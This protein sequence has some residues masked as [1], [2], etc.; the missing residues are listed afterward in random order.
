MKGLGPLLEG[1]PIEVEIDDS[2]P[3]AVFDAEVIEKVIRQL[4]D[5][6]IKYSPPGSPIRISAEFTGVELVVS[7]ADSGCGIPKSDQQRIFEKYYR[8]RAAGS[9]VPGTGLGLASAKCIL[10]AHGG[11]IWVNSAP[12]A[13]SIFRISLPVTLEASPEQLE[14]SE[15]R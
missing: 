8:G 6:A 3:P 2:L 12:G 5:N 11:E 1:R 4:I 13:G 10:E 14:D 7:V 9:D 15:R